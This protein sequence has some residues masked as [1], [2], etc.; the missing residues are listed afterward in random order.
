MNAAIELHD[1]EV[2]A[3]VA[4]PEGG[5][6]VRLAPAYVHRSAGRPGIDAGSGWLQAVELAFASAV[7]EG[8]LPELPCELDG[9]TLTGVESRGMVPLPYATDA[10]V[11]FEAHTLTGGR[12]SAR[13]RGLTVRAAGEAR[14]VEEFPGL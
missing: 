12:I 4:T 9:G 7:I 14:Y 8:P 13:G 1:S 10:A 6:V 11:H 3:V 5:V 2:A